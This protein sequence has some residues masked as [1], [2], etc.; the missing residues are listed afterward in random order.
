M[1]VV[2]IRHGEAAVGVPDAKRELTRRGR[3]EVQ[4]ALAVYR[5]Y[6]RRSAIGEISGESRFWASPLLRAQQTAALIVNELGKKG[7][8]PSFESSTLLEPEMDPIDVV[9]L[10]ERA[11]TQGV[12]ELWLV[13]HNPL[14]SNL[15][16]LLTDGK[17]NSQ[18]PLATAEIVELEVEWV[19][20]GCATVGFRA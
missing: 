7:V 13:A 16:S 2:I 3:E 15:L 8:T 4:N 17:L 10:L 9:A 20:L 19:G 14:L 11:E 5:A 6:R 1:L 12:T 18:P